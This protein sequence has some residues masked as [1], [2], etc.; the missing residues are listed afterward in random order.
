MVLRYLL[1]TNTCI[2]IRGKQPKIVSRFEKL[3]P[4]EV[5]ISVIAY[6]ELAYGVSKSKQ[7]DRA[8]AGLERFIAS[9]P[10]LPMPIEAGEA[11]GHLR[12]ALEEKGEIIGPNDL[13][14]AAHALV[15]G[16][17]LVTNNEREFKRVKDLKFENWTK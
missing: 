2:Y 3:D 8:I 10:V 7:S 9:I 16:L 1:D 11:Y 13:W 5:G 15:S 4:G 12:A 17:T 14:I 6:G